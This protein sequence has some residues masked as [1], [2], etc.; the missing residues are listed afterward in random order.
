M[1]STSLI[2]LVLV[3]TEKLFSATIADYV[4]S[5]PAFE[6]A[7]KHTVTVD[8]QRA[9][10]FRTACQPD[11]CQLMLPCKCFLMILTG[12]GKHLSVFDHAQLQGVH[13]ELGI[14]VGLNAPAH[15]L[16]NHQ[17][18]IACLL[19]HLLGH[20]HAYEMLRFP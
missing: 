13:A 9:A 4:M 14:Q 8:S 16:K 5:I 15:A 2:R 10:H 17:I 1:T 18:C 12:S 19:N 3:F 11:P 7:S 20:L 6:A